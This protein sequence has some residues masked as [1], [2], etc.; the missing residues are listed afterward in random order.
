MEA[1]MKKKKKKRKKKDGEDASEGSE[2]EEGGSEK[3]EAD[4]KQ[5]MD[6]AG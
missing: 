1:K 4:V 6:F 3:G 2:V 5:Q